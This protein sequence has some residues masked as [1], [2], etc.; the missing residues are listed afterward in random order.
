M[1]DQ[2]SSIRR[3]DKNRNESQKDY[4]KDWSKQREKVWVDDISTDQY[5]SSSRLLGQLTSSQNIYVVK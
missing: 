5:Q 2:S 3:I 4:Y 1:N